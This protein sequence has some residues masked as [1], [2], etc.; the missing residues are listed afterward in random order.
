MNRANRHSFN[1]PIFGPKIGPL[2]HAGVGELHDRLLMV[3]LKGALTCC[4]REAFTGL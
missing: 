3:G 2:R 1:F 4:V